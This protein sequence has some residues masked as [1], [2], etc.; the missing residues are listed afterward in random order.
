MVESKQSGQRRVIFLDVDGVLVSYRGWQRTWTK[1]QEGE[2]IFNTGNEAESPVEK[3][4]VQ[5]LRKVV[6][7]TEKN[8]GQPCDIVLS[9]TWRYVGQLRKFLIEQVLEGLNVVGDT[10]SAPDDR[11]DQEIITWLKSAEA[12]DVA[13]FVVIDDNYAD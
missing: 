7:R 8:T 10:P 2:L 11:R 6:K 1:L 9:T 3:F 4:N 5:Q 12:A 13:G